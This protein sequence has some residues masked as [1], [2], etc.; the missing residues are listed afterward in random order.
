LTAVPEPPR[1]V[2]FDLDG[3]L[4][5]SAGDIAAALNAVLDERG[6]ATLPVEEVRALTGYGAE[7]LVRRAFAAVGAPLAPEAVRPATERYLEH[8]GAHPADRTTLFADAGPALADLRARGFRVAVCTN[9]ETGLAERVLEALGVAGAVEAVVGADAVE[10]R[11]PDPRH[12]EAALAAI[13][14]TADEAVY[15]GDTVVDSQAAAAAGL[16]CAMVAWGAPEAA[17]GPVWARLERFGELPAL[18]AVDGA[19]TTG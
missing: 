3:T 1:A 14:A 19:A 15:V 11:K 8:Y 9:K 2:L 7:E 13:D 10:H 4:V 17:T 6:L 16:R 18:L 5:D 12:L